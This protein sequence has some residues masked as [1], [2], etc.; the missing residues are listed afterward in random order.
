[1]TKKG[2]GVHKWNEKCYESFQR[3]KD[4]ITSAPVLVAPDWKKPFR[5]HIDASERAVGG[6]LTQLDENGRDRVISFF[7]KKLAPEEVNYTSNDRELLG[8]IRFL[9]RFR[10]YLEGWEFEIFTDNQVLKNLFTKKDLSRREARW[11]ETLG[12]F[13]IFPITL[14]PG[15]I[16][17][18]GDTLSRA[19]HVKGDVNVNDV[20]IPFIRFEEVIDEYSEDQF[21]GQIVKSMDGNYSDDKKLKLKLEK[22][23][24]MFKM[25]GKKLI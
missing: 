15:K 25:D 19:P 23:V 22:L 18:L 7:S 11:I 8:L 9:Q 12:N 3:L 4:A 10:C 13:G 20:E 24:P 2:S 1:M 17:V 6:T 14:K 5:G 21:F 16:H